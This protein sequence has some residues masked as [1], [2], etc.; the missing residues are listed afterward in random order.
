MEKA[1]KAH[2]AISI[3]FCPMAGDSRTVL[4]F[5]F[6]A[7]SIRRRRDRLAPGLALAREATPYLRDFLYSFSFLF[8]LFTPP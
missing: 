7:F 1:P 8:S 4:S 2:S 5:Y 3:F 6:F